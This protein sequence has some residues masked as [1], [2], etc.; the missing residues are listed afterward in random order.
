[1]I[2]NI[3]NSDIEAGAII[4]QPVGRQSRTSVV[5]VSKHSKMAL[6]HSHEQ[7]LSHG[8]N[9]ELSSDPATNDLN[10]DLYNTGQKAQTRTD[11]TLTNQMSDT[12]TYVKCP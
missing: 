1:M 3:L 7:G 2:D 8:R 11:Q 5:K 4:R 10:N 6:I 12:N 9:H